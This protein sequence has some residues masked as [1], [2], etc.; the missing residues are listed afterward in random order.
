[1]SCMELI[2]FECVLCP[3]HLSCLALFN[4]LNNPSRLVPILMLQKRLRELASDRLKCGPRCY[5]LGLLGIHEVKERIRETHW[6]RV[7]GVLQY[8]CLKNPM[9]SMKMAER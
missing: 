4:P 7:Q 1:M 8:F 9:N 5:P 6:M 3:R 2:L